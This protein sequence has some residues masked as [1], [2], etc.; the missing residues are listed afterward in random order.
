[1]PRG[2]G[3]GAAMTMSAALSRDLRSEI[4][5]RFC[6]SVGADSR[7]SRSRSRCCGASGGDLRNFFF[8]AQ[9]GVRRAGL[10]RAGGAESAV[11]G[12]HARAHTNFY[13]AK[14]CPFHRHFCNCAKIGRV[15]S[16]ARAARAT[17]AERAS[18]CFAPAAR[19]AA[20]CT[21]FVNA[22]AVFFVLL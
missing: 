16:A 15:V 2:S 14:K 20:A 22:E 7:D 4:E 9:N 12:L 1:M 13:A 5:R 21:R 6:E 10:H 11:K 8:A 17:H 18:R 19:E 3:I